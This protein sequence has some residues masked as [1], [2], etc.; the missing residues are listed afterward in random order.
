MPAVAIT[1]HGY[2]YGA[3]DFHLNSR[4]SIEAAC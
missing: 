4:A 3:Y 2:M 1:D